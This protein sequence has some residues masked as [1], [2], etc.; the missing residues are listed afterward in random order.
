MVTIGVI[1]LLLGGTIMWLRPRSY[2]LVSF[3]AERRSGL[4]YI[5]QSLQRYKDDTG[6]FPA[7]IPAE[8]ASISSEEGEEGYDLCAALVPGYIEDIPF[9]PAINEAYLQQEE[10]SDELSKRCDK[11]SDGYV[12]GYTIAKEKDGGVR[13]TAPLAQTGKI[14]IKVR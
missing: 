14:E 13:L 8:A 4:A 5:A 7:T 11:K 12:S 1:G 9:D 3:D 2:T 10:L 6:Q